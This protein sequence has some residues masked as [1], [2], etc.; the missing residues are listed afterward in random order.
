MNLYTVH[1]FSSL[2]NFIHLHVCIVIQQHVLRSSSPL[3]QQRRSNDYTFLI[4]YS[5]IYIIFYPFIVTYILYII[6]ERL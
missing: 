2:A 3:I 6:V 4:F 1:P 5:F